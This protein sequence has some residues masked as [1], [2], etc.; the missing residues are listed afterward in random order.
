MANTRT[1]AA[2]SV[3][4]F[5][6]VPPL[7]RVERRA[8]EAFDTIELGDLGHRQSAAGGDQYVCLM[9]TIARCD[10]PPVSGAVPARG[11]NLGVGVDAVEYAA[12]AR[13]ILDIGLDLSLRG[14]A[15]GPSGL[16]EKESS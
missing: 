10:Q 8:L 9:I 6:I 12:A 14:V 1:S 4:S 13:H 11:Q 3:P 2:R 7:R 5:D 16:G 15:A